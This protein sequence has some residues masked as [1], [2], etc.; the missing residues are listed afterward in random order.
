VTTESTELRVTMLSPLA[1]E[2]KERRVQRQHLRH[3]KRA[4]SLNR[5]L[6]A[7]LMRNHVYTTV[8]LRICI[9]VNT[10]VHEGRI[11][12]GN[13]N[14][15]SAFREPSARIGDIRFSLR[16][17]RKFWHVTAYGLTETYKK[18]RR[19]IT[20]TY[21]WRKLIRYKMCLVFLRDFCSKQPPP[22]LHT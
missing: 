21:S 14:I 22:R 16:S 15:G 2:N 3:T 5:G 11:W 9:F 12:P 20:P 1:T 10:E 18:I 6:Q 19:N 4:G 17:R 7:L 13:C 8:V